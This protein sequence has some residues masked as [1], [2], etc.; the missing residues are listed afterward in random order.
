MLPDQ[1]G[2]SVRARFLTTAASHCAPLFKMV[3]DKR[4]VINFNQWQ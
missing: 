1:G 3:F 2:G 4:R